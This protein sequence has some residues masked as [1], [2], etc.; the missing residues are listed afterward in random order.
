MRSMKTKRTITILTVTA[1]LA[2]L[3][4]LLAPGLSAATVSD[5]TM[6]SVPTGKATVGAADNALDYQWFTLANSAADNAVLTLSPAGK[7][8]LVANDAAGG[9]TQLT[10][11]QVT[12]PG[13]GTVT[14]AVYSPKLAGVSL[15][16]TDEAGQN[17]QLSGLGWYWVYFQYLEYNASPE[18]IIAYERESIAPGGSVSK[19]PPASFSYKGETYVPTDAS[20]R[21]LTYN[22]GMTESER[23]VKIYYQPYAAQAYNVTV[24]YVNS[25][26]GEVLLSETKTVPAPTKDASGATVYPIIAIKPQQI[27]TVKN[28]S[29]KTVTYKL[30]PSVSQGTRVHNYQDGA[31]TYSFYMVE[32]TQIP[33]KS[34]QISIRYIDK[35]TGL[36]LTTQRE[37]IIVD[38]TQVTTTTVDIP[39]SF[40]STTG[41]RYVRCV[42][43][44]ATIDHLSNDTANTVKEVYF[45]ID[46]T[47]PTTDY[48]ITIVYND[49]ATNTEVKRET[50][51]VPY[52]SGITFVADTKFDANGTTYTLAVGED[53]R[54]VH[55]FADMT[56]LYILNYNPAGSNLQPTT[57]TINYAEN[58]NNSA[59]YTTTVTVP[60][61]DV[62]VHIA[63]AKYDANGNT[64]VLLS[65]Q[66]RMI[67][68]Y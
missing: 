67:Y 9:L 49:A 63:P 51:N 38:P 4:T 15:W 50:V 40:V 56:R 32:D 66:S 20:P 36:I 13:G 30:D 68:N 19:V 21:A 14:V 46:K 29:G 18:T 47:L 8:Y 61:N 5:I 17:K 22:S 57:V 28:A 33:G 6:A 48:D 39:D 59:L 31:K 3:L 11:D 35:D 53:R 25:L 26:N 1:L 62:L 37:T 65:G 34:Y 24:N 10:N 2:A 45:E 54:I 64:F 55:D 7:V 52:L 43:E 16:I 60:V 58:V 23:T 12:V 44:P 42:G 41:R 27:I